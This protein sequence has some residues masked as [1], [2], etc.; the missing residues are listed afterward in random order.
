MVKKK[1]AGGGELTKQNTNDLG[2]AR[3]S[4]MEFLL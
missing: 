1:K 3:L 4:Y 2:R